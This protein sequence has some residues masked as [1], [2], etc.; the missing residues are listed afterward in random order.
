M[1][2]HGWKKDFVGGAAHQSNYGYYKEGIDL[3]KYFKWMFVRNPYD[4]LVSSF[5]YSQ[6]TI[7]R[8]NVSMRNHFWM[9]ESF[10]KYVL[11]LDELFNFSLQNFDQ[12]VRN[13]VNAHVIP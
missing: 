9:L 7:G 2:I 6:R 3:G 10:E 5:C 4:R 12:D 8:K 1:L 11:N 13:F